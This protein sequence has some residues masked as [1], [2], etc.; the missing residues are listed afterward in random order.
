MKFASREDAGRQLGWFLLGRAWEADVVVGLPRGGV[1]VA[2]E[3]ARL[4][5]LPLDVL[6]VRKIG[7]PLHREFAVG[8]LAEK[9]IVLLDQSAI[10]S[11]PALITQLERVIDEETGRLRDYERKFRGLRE[12]H[13][14]GRRV[15]LVDDGLATGAT[16]EAAV[17]SLKKQRVARVRVVVPVAS[18]GGMERLSHLADD[19]I[20]LVVDRGFQAVG[21]YYDVFMPTTDDEVM[22]ALQAVRN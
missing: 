2:A 14:E 7:H 15:L 12:P 6:I 5:D 11:N 16:M 17:M 18:P 1:I 9:G 3:V 13:F 21:A 4:L 8:A 19:V 22:Q 10:G 20:A